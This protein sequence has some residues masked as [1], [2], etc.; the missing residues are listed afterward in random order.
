[1]EF[2]GQEQFLENQTKDHHPIKE[3]KPL[4][5]KNWEKIFGTKPKEVDVTRKPSDLNLKD[6]NA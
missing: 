2:E 3:T 1:M 6:T 5:E 4:Y